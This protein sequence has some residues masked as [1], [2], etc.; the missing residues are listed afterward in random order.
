MH[1][2]VHVMVAMVIY[3]HITVL[4]DKDSELNEL[5]GTLEGEIKE[6]R[7]MIET[8]KKQ[9]RLVMLHVVLNWYCMSLASFLLYR[10]E[11][12]KVGVL[13]AKNEALVKEVE[14]LKRQ[15]Q[16]RDD[17]EKEQKAFINELE[18]KVRSKEEETR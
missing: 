15:L 14:S 2:Y 4:R 18:A 8:L 12:E 13:T 7:R 3:L 5:R 10:L 9:L 6:L 17:K 1:Y 16:E 11:E